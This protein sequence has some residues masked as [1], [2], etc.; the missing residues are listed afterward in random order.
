MFLQS[1]C[2]YSDSAGKE[3]LK[4]SLH[5]T[6]HIMDPAEHHKQVIEA[7]LRR[8]K[9]DCPKAYAAMT[10]KDSLKKGIHTALDLK[11]MGDYAGI[12]I[13]IV[14]YSSKYAFVVHNF[15]LFY[16]FVQASK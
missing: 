2:L 8:V 4:V 3:D 1:G 10:E 6:I 7:C 9:K 11:D 13:T 5:A 12:I 16:W 14:V 15:G